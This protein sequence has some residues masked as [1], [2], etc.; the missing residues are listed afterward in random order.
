MR[1]T[2]TAVSILDKDIIQA[3]P[4]IRARKDMTLSEMRLFVLGLQDIRPHIKDDHIHDTDFHE[5]FISY[6]DLM[7]L[8]GKYCNGNVTNLRRHIKKAYQA[9]IELSYEDGGFGFRHI[10]KKM[11]YKPQEGLVIQFDE[12][13]KPYILEILNQA[14]TKYKV[15]ALFSLSSVYAWRILESLLEKQ[16]FLKQG[17]KQIF[18]E[19]DIEALRF[20]L[21]I[22]DGLY[23]DKMC[24]FRSRVLDLPIKDINE[25]TDYIV[26]YDVIKTGRKVSGFKFW[27]KLKREKDVC[28][29]NETSTKMANFVEEMRLEGMTT[30]SINTWLKRNGVE[31]AAASWRLAVEHANEKSISGDQR[32]RYLKTCMDRNISAIN[33]GED[34]L[35]AE[36]DEREKRLAKEKEEHKRQDLELFKELKEL[37]SPRTVEEIARGSG[38]LA[39]LAKKHLMTQKTK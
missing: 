27:L 25:K 19:I 21:N 33:E 17:E 6:I 12:E 2:T 22:P 15:K 3:N 26:W 1:R 10:Y 18:W 20:R 24:N 5:T 7:E 11:D 29:N 14:Y 4:L 39:D 34:A 36:I 23:K 8:F 32:Y 28:K 9:V 35:K 37:S 31:G 38:V 30:K 16:G 13:I